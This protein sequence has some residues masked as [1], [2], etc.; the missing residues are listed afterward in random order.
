VLPLLA[1]AQVD[2]VSAFGRFRR[3]MAM[4]IVLLSGVYLIAVADMSNF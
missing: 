3:C 1:A 2:S 4:R